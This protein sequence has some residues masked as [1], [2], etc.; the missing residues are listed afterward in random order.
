M[1]YIEKLQ[2]L[3]DKSLNILKS[4]FPNI[5]NNGLFGD[6]YKLLAII[7]VIIVLLIICIPI[8]YISYKI[9]INIQFMKRTSFCKYYSNMFKSKTRYFSYYICI[10]NI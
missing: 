2:T 5:G 10:V 4:K 8:F 9:S 6:N 7:I 1:T 3:K